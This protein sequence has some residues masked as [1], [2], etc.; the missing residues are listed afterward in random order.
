MAN[1]AKQLAINLLKG[2][3]ISHISLPVRIFE[4]RS[5]ISRICDIWAHVSEYFTKAS[6]CSDPVEKMKLG[7]TAQVACFY[8]CTG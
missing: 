6:E 8:V 3:S 5:T 7:V 1:L 2:L 4:P